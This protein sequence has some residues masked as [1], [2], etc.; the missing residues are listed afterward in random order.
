MEKLDIR[1]KILVLNPLFF[2]YI[3]YVYPIVYTVFNAVTSEVTN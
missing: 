2:I 3:V 1:C